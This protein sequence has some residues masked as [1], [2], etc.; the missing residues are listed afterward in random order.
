MVELTKKTF[1]EQ[2][3]M[4]KIPVMILHS[5]E[6][7]RRNPSGKITEAV[8]LSWNAADPFLKAVDG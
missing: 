1:E 4:S 6:H 3:L 8:R 5:G 2:V 7:R